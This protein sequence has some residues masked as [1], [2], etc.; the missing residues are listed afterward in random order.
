MHKEIS[1]IVK[2]TN[3]CNLNCPYCYHFKHNGDKRELHMK[4]DTIE[5]T[6]RQLINHNK[7]NAH[8]IWHGGEPMLLGLDVFRQ[9]VQLQKKYCKPDMNIS[10]AI[11]TNGTLLTDEWIIFFVENDFHVGISVDGYKELHMKSRAVHESAFNLI[12]EKIKK[13][14]QAAARFGVLT[15][16][17]KNTLGHADEL[18]QF[19]IESG[20]NDIGFL[21]S[22][23]VNDGEIDHNCTLTA[24]EYGQFLI[25]FF[26]VWVNSGK[27][28]MS[29][30]E[31]D[32]YFRSKLKVRHRLCINSN[33]CDRYYTVTPD[34]KIYLCDCF[35]L[36]AESYVGSIF[37]PVDAVL[38]NNATIDSF[39]E[40][41]KSPPSACK[42][43]SFKKICNGGCKYYRWLANKEMN[44][45]HL[46]C[47][48]FK[49]LYKQMDEVIGEIH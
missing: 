23:V 15:V 4:M 42:A 34:G 30:R 13:L 41:F 37:D 7:H 3:D 18:L 20:I 12:L 11:Q 25:D 1:F 46:Y 27:T 26:D 17:G 49:Q 21:P 14:N 16:I 40:H 44:R 2:L 36:E 43:C 47:S 5:Q 39:R 32:E 38:S 8:F 24:E 19:F 35:P 31:F 28:G 29:I 33:E 45:P 10:N 22:T 48:A 9:I 6:I